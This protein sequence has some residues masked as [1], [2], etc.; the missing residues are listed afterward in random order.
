MKK[1]KVDNS[2]AEAAAKAQA[3][4]T[5]IANNLQRNF[6]ADLKTDNLSTVTAGGSADDSMVGS[7]GIKRRK[8]STGL[9]SQLGIQV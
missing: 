8:S 1:A 2:G 9:S 3:E 5:A 4:A 7:M 6:Q